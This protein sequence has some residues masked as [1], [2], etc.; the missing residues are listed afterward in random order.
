MN[1]ILDKIAKRTAEFLKDDMFVELY[2]IEEINDFKYSKNSSFITLIGDFEISVMIDIDN[3]L[4]MLMFHN[5]F[6]DI[7]D[8]IEN[9]EKNELLEALSD[10]I[11][12]I[13][14]GLSM[15]T[16]P[17]EYK[18]FQLGVPFKKNRMDIEKIIEENN[19][20]SLEISTNKGNLVC[21]VIYT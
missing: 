17:S 7:L 6:K 12:N 3:E 18:D 13:V 20:D 8:D 1:I 2:N 5:L 9:E 14:V 16:F 21:T 4:F 10:E 15:K 11:I 19:S